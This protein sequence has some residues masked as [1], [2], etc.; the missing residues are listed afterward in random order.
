MTTREQLAAECKRLAIEYGTSLCNRNV[1]W[2]ARNLSDLLALIDRLA[3]C[4][5]LTTE[6]AAQ[7]DVLEEAMRLVIDYHTAIQWGV[8]KGS[9]AEKRREAL[10][11]FLAAHLMSAEDEKNLAR[12]EWLKHGDNDEKVLRMYGDSA[13]TMYLPRLH[14]LDAAIDAA[15]GKAGGK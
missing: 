15:M 11:T 8:Y 4:Q 6:P 5:P 14:H 2:A 7:S 3:A 1:Q 12:Y 9:K 13:D 10:R